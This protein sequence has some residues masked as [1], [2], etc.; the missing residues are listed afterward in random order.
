MHVGQP[1]VA[2]LEFEHQPFMVDSQEVQ[3]GCLEIMDVDRVGGH[4]LAGGWVEFKR[5]LGWEIACF[6]VHIFSH[7]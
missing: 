7:K 3:D 1:I 5:P 6:C 4:R 2:A